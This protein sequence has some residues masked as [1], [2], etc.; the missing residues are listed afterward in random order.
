MTTVPDGPPGRGGRPVE[1]LPVDEL[2][3]E[4]LVAVAVA[5]AAAREVTPPLTAGEGW[6]AQRVDWLRSFHRERR[7]GLEGPQGE[8][9]WAV[10]V[11]GAVVGSV[12]LRQTAEPGV[13][14]T[15]IWLARA[16]RGRGTGRRALAE[17][18][19]AG[20]SLGYAELR[21][22]TTSGNRPAL[23]LLAAVGFHLDLPDDAGIVV[24]RLELA[25]PAAG[26][27]PG[28]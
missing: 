10:V 3:L 11:D 22:E 15:G 2:V 20:R 16:A 14:E 12:R 19:R 9:T 8:A 6:S 26:G 24:A 27:S 21:A 18:V 17:V 23:A 25:A 28:R 7:A 13:V 1:L 4:R 5:D